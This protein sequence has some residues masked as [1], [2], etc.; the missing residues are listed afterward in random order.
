[1]LSCALFLLTL[2]CLNCAGFYNTGLEAVRFEWGILDRLLDR[3]GPGGAPRTPLHR[4]GTRQK[5]KLAPLAD[6]GSTWLSVGDEVKYANEMRARYTLLNSAEGRKMTFVNAG[7]P[8][9]IA[10]QAEVL[11]MM[12]VWLPRQH[13][14]RFCV[15]RTGGTVNT[16]TPGYRHTFKISDFAADPLRLAGMLV[17][18]D[19]YLL[20][21]QSAVPVDPVSCASVNVVT[22]LCVGP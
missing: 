3:A 15:D 5:S 19:L 8:D 20:Q 21:E 14:S 2:R 6:P 1:V 18:E 4:W 13:P 16:T 22:G 11:E 10:G 12:L 7:D 9:C 17:Q